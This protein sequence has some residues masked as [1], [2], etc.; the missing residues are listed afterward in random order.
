MSHAHPRPKHPEPDSNHGI[1]RD[2][3]LYC[4]GSGGLTVYPGKSG[5]MERGPSYTGWY[6]GVQIWATPLDR[7][8]GD[9]VDWLIWAGPVA[10]LIEV[11]PESQFRKDGELYAGRLRPGEQYTLENHPGPV[12]ICTTVEDVRAFVETLMC[13]QRPDEGLIAALVHIKDWAETSVI[14]ARKGKTHWQ[15]VADVAREALEG[16]KA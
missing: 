5:T 9:V 7:I 6:Q 12:K 8:G 2:F 15:F 1:V 4:C 10:G 3:V 14:H 11:K 16:K 13:T